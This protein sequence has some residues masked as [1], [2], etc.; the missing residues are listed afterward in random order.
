LFGFV[1][2]HGSKWW[3]GAALGNIVYGMPSDDDRVLKI[4]TATERVSFIERVHGASKNSW[5]G[6]AAV[7]TSIYGIPYHASGV[8]KIDTVTG[9]TTVMENFGKA[10]VPRTNAKWFGGVAVGANVYGIPYRR[11]DFIKIR[12]CVESPAGPTWE[13]KHR[14]TAASF[15]SSAPTLLLASLLVAAVCAEDL[16]AFKQ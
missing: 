7:G 5:F 6:A 8:L 9:R 15:A 13:D 11:H 1:G 16:L 12:T 3:G 2:S 14:T 4:D 10:R